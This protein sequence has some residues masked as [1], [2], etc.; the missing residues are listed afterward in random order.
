MLF[1][2]GL[3]AMLGGLFGT[4]MFRKSPPPVV[5]PPVPPQGF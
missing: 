3:F 2:G 1:V 4:L 5:P